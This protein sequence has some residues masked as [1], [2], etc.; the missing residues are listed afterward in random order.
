MTNSSVTLE[1]SLVGGKGVFKE[2]D[3]ETD[4]LM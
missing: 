4:L 3:V 1:I 2:M